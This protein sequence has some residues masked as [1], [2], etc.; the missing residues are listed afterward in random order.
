MALVA[1]H[2]WDVD[3]ARRAGLQGYYADRRRTAYPKAFLEP[4]LVVPDLIALADAM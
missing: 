3:G 2:P 1:V 4:D